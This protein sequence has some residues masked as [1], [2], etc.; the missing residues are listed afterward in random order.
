V[1]KPT[2]VPV[3]KLSIYLQPFHRTSF[4]ECVLQPKIAKINKNPSFWKFRV[5]QVI[6]VNMTEKLITSACCDR[7]HWPCLSA[8]DFTKDWPLP[9]TVK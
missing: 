5:F 6:D 4:L 9:T 1:Q 3:R 2:A 7:Y 8:T